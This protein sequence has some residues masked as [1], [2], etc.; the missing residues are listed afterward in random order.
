[1]VNMVNRDYRDLFAAFNESEVEFMIVGA[2][3]LAVHGHLRATKDL[4]VW[5][6]PSQANAVRVFRALQAFGAPTEGL[7]E[8]DFAAPG[9]IVQLGFPPVRI[10]LLTSIDGVSF[11]AAWSR[12]TVASYGDEAVSVISRDDLITNKRASGRLQDLAD[13]EALEHG[14]ADDQDA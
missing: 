13:V 10:D 7:T 9:V 1:M 11:D 5:V 4:D 14:V 6:H 3:A 12:R 8:S 2:Y